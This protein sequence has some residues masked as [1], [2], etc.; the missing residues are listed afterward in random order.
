MNSPHSA[1][2]RTWLGK[3]L[4]VSGF[5]VL[6]YLG[7]RHVHH[8]STFQHGSVLLTETSLCTMI[9]DRS[10]LLSDLAHAFTR[11]NVTY[12]IGHG[13]L[14]EVSRGRLIYRNDDIDIR[15]RTD[16]YDAFF[17]LCLAEY[18]SA[19]GGK[20]RCVP[21]EG[22]PYDGWAHVYS[23]KSHITISADVVIA[24]P[25][26]GPQFYTSYVDAVKSRTKIQYMGVEVW[27]PANPGL[28][29][30]DQY[31]PAFNT[32]DWTSRGAELIFHA[33][34]KWRPPA[35]SDAASESC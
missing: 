28:V 2:T 24:A 9:H 8:M 22:E 5:I 15:I 35:A 16:D 31:G 18:A 34:S 17:S 3:A 29:L 32:S 4:A 6:A 23:T 20:L 10:E 26:P 12:V 33:R 21:A 7:Y 30:R 14:I 11:W 25:L 1:K 19:E 13:N 27:A